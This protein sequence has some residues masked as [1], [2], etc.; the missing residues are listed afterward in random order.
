ML[1]GSGKADKPQ[2]KLHFRTMR[3]LHNYCAEPKCLRCGY[4][5]RGQ[6]MAGIEQCS[7]CGQACRKEDLADQI[8]EVN[9]DRLPIL[10]RVLAS[11]YLLWGL[12]LPLL[13]AAG[14]VISM[15][16]MIGIDADVFFYLTLIPL[17]LL[18]PVGIIVPI[19]MTRAF[20]KT[21]RVL[22]LCLFGHISALLYVIMFSGVCYWFSMTADYVFK[23]LH[24][25]AGFGATEYGFTTIWPHLV[26]AAVVLIA[27]ANYRLSSRYLVSPCRRRCRILVL[28]YLNASDA[29]LQRS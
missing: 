29:N 13:A 26:L 9:W 22:V 4:D 18:W 3:A 27:L 19:V 17:G 7:E 28:A 6:F 14:V 23:R 20:F 8:S 15:L 10:T 21:G 1:W 16:F 11:A 2:V 5:L 24:I 25:A 12:P